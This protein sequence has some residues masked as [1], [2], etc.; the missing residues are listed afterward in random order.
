MPIIT[1]STDFGNKDPDA[2]FLKT[3]I[4]HE[5]ADAHIVDVTHQLK[6]FDVEEAVY[7]LKN[8]LTYFPKGSIHL[9]AFDSEVTARNKAI[10]VQS[11]KYFFL[12]NDNGIIPEIL[13]GEL[14]KAFDIS[15]PV[16]ERFMLYHIEAIKKITQDAFPTLFSKELHELKRYNFAKPVLKYEGNLVK[17]IFPRVIYVDNYGNAVFNLKREEFEAYRQNRKFSIHTDFDLIT[18]MSKGYHDLTSN[19]PGGIYGQAGVGFN[20]FGYLEIFM[21]S[22]NYDRG[23]ANNL[24]GLSKNSQIKIS[25]D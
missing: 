16:Y 2:A 10:V 5:I 6:P 11:E 1:L 8:S 19:D 12:T 15:A 20:T 4:L 3:R 18:K 14:Y 17:Y 22:S 9:I 25:F 13:E 24:L 7:I 21:N 23:G